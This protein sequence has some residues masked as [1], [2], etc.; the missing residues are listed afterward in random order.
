[1]PALLHGAQRF[2]F[3]RGDAAGDVARRGI[4][5]HRLAVAQEVVLEVVDDGDDAVE[6]VARP[7][8]RCI[9]SRSAPKISGNLGQHR[10]AAGAGDAIGDRADERIRGDAAEAVR[11][12]ALQA[13]RPDRSSAQGTRCVALRDL[14]RALRRR[15]G[16]LRVSSSVACAA[17][18]RM[19]ARSAFGN[20]AEQLLELIRF[21]AQA[22]DQHAAGVRMARERGDQLARA[23]EI[24][25]ELR[26]AELMRK[27]V[28]AIDATGE[29]LRAAAARCVPRCA[30]RSRRCTESRS[31]CE[32]R[33][34]R[35]RGDSRGKSR[36]GSRRR[37]RSVRRG[38]YR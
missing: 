1:M 10:G 27:R 21:A 24:A 8:A 20:L 35:S 17:K 16:L 29:A 34:G 2:L 37:S 5:V 25:A 26:A 23:I 14:A 30:R 9:S 18:E 4:L 12:A 36:R 22:E 6:D 3:E 38:S 13:D 31:R 15:A 19:R 33:R 7:A 11:A 32:C 28:H